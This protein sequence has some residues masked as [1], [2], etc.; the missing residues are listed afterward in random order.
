M[1]HISLIVA[2]KLKDISAVGCQ[3][4]CTATCCH[5]T[6]SN[7]FEQLYGCLVISKSDYDLKLDNLFS[8]HTDIYCFQTFSRP[9]EAIEC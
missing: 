8:D 5:T 1:I 9:A 2:G 6:L 3:K 7:Y 4:I